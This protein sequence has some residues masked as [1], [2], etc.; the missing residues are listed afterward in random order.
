M[1]RSIGGNYES[2]G[3][4]MTYATALDDPHSWALPKLVVSGNQGWYPQVIGDPDIRGT[5]KLSGSRARYFN[6]GQS[7]SLIVFTD[8][9]TASPTALACIPPNGC[10]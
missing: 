5:D 2:G 8:A 9:S 10:R 1:S 6:Q 4:Y 7:D 3:I